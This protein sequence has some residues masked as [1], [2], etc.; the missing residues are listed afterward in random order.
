L[1]HLTADDPEPVEEDI[2]ALIA[3]RQ[4]NRNL[5]I[6]IDSDK[7]NA[8]A[9]INATKQRIVAEMAGA[10][11]LAWIT[12]GREIENYVQSDT[13]KDA[14][15]EAYPSRFSKRNKTGRYDHVLPFRT[16]AG[17]IAKDIDKVKVA[18][19]VCSRPAD[20]DVLDLR[21]RI[22]ALVELIRGANV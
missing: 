19:A 7:A 16:I 5:A 11:G 2:Q 12:A 22:E 8:D 10:P 20:L 4:L 6:V 18:R 15:C 17:P 1:S 3:V 21:R 9:P 14:L 13:L